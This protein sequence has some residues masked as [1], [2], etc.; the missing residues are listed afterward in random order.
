MSVLIGSVARLLNQLFW[1]CLLLVA[2][3]ASG[4]AQPPLTLDDAVS[5]ALGENAGRRAQRLHAALARTA[6]SSSSP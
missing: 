2:H 4:A 3:I 6:Q 1:A 5:I